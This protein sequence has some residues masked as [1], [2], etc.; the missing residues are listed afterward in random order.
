[1]EI[2]ADYLTDIYDGSICKRTTFGMQFQQMSASIFSIPGFLTFCGS[3][4][5]YISILTF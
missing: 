4:K 5:D 2:S 1:M 3:K